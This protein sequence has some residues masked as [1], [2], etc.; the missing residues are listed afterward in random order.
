MKTT[1]SFFQPKNF[2]WLITSVVIL[3]LLIWFTKTTS[4]YDIHP[5]LSV[6]QTKDNHQSSSQRLSA[7]LQ[8]CPSAS[9][10]VL[11]IPNVV[12]CYKIT[13]RLRYRT[14]IVCV[15]DTSN[16]NLN[17]TFRDNDMYLYIYAHTS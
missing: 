14:S 13:L 16:I 1:K 17:M 15:H 11:Y 4:R 7:V 6:C 5:V 2:L 3:I 9:G 12:V 8:R 10:M